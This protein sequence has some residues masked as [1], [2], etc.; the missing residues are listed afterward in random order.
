MSGPSLPGL[1]LAAAK[2]IERVP[3]ALAGELVM[4]TLLGSGYARLAPDRATGLAELVDAVRAQADGAVAT[5]LGEPAPVRFTGGY[6]YGDRYGDESGYLATF[7]H[8]GDGGEEHAPHGEAHREV[9]D[10]DQGIRHRGESAGGEGD[11][12][13]LLPAD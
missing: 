9:P 1:I 10:L 7:A 8:D 11:R 12:A 13:G 2:D 4:S 5:L 3:G 6:A